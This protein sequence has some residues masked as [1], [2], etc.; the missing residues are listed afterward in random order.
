MTFK[1]AIH[2]IVQSPNWNLSR[3]GAALGVSRQAISNRINRSDGLRLPNAIE[4]AEA[5]GYDLVLVPKHSRLPEGSFR[6][7]V[8]GGGKDE[9]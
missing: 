3:L 5:L 6:I 4:M 9:A 2:S 8:E 7:T 1:D